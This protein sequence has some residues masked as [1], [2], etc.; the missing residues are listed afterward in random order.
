[1]AGAF[2]LIFSRGRGMRLNRIAPASRRSPCRA[3]SSR[4]DQTRGRR[5]IIPTCRRKIALFPLPLPH[6]GIGQRPGRG[7][8]GRGIERH[9]AWSRQ[10]LNAASR[11]PARV[12]FRILAI[13]PNP[14]PEAPERRCGGDF[15][16][17]GCVT[18]VVARTI[19][20][21]LT[22]EA[23]CMSRAITGLVNG[24]NGSVGPC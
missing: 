4:R 10:L 23:A 6:T 24:K 9:A 21:Q 15:Q 8:R 17:R 13:L 16:N 1:M 20:W 19:R 3:Q 18:H 2:S 5:I 7:R 11:S 12:V 14:S 22:A